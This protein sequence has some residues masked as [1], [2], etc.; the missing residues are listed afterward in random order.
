MT[1]YTI[2]IIQAKVHEIPT[3]D[4]ENYN[5]IIKANSALIDNS[6]TLPTTP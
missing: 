3:I 2:A 5:N 6:H 1:P 4:E